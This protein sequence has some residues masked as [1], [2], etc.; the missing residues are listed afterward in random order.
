MSAP[1]RTHRLV[2]PPELAPPRGFAHASVIASGRVVFLAGQVG[3][4]GGGA[5]VSPDLVEQYGQALG[6]L[7]SA[8]RACGGSPEHLVSLQIFTTRMRE[9]RERLPELGRRH[10]SHLGKHYPPTSLLGLTELF[11]VDAAVEIVGV[12]VIPV[13]EGDDAC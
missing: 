4:D 6:N 13:A 8:L 2:N 1:Q 5:I 12:A 9:Y 7:V 3:H 11:D 10:R